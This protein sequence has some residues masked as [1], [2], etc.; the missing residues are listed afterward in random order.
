MNLEELQTLIDQGE[1]QRLEF[2]RGVLSTKDLA[3]MV[4]CLANAEGGRLLLGV[5]TRAISLAVAPT[6]SLTCFPPS[7]ALPSP[8]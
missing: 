4:I 8:P 7:I 5:I 3:E 1:G 2:K 6:T